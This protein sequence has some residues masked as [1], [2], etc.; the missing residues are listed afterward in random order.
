M[1]FWFLLHSRCKCKVCANFDQ[2]LGDRSIYW[3]LSVSNAIQW[4]TWII[5]IWNK[6]QNRTMFEQF[7]EQNCCSWTSVHKNLT[8]QHK[9]FK[10]HSLWS[11]I[12]IICNS[13]SHHTDSLQNVSF[14]SLTLKLF[15]LC[16][17]LILN[18]H[19]V[20]HA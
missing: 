18:K 2:I 12:W 7:N 14:I 1:C 11:L 10:Y 6:D 15:L 3:K 17:F 4:S 9:L 8:Q 16:S 19:N 5:M 20:M 13:E